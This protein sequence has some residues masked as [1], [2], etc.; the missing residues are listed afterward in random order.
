M[1]KSVPAIKEPPNCAGTSLMQKCVTAA[2][3]IYFTL[4]QNYSIM[5]E[6]KTQGEFLL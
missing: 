2:Q 6:K 5:Q 1:L 3:I 4:F